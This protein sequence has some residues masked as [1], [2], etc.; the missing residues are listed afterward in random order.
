M[1]TIINAEKRRGNL[2]IRSYVHKLLRD[3]KASFEDGSTSLAKVL[4][5][6]GFSC[7]EFSP[8]DIEDGDSILGAVSHSEKK[9]FLNETLANE[10][11]YFTLAHEIGHAVLH[12]H[13]KE[14]DYQHRY[15][16]EVPYEEVEANVFAYEILLPVH[17]FA[18]A[19]EKFKGDIASL[20]K[21]FC[22]EPR[23]ILKRKNFLKEEGKSIETLFHNLTSE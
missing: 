4:A 20:S 12:P 16:D 13:W 11:K 15:R 19:D 3:S 14:I 5:Y 21:L 9:F 6:L 17:S 23:R 7:Y 2:L 10:Q 1:K 22:V 18:E 8:S